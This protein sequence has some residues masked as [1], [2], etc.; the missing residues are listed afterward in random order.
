MKLQTITQVL[1]TLPRCAHLE[2]CMFRHLPALQFCCSHSSPVGLWGLLIRVCCL[3]LTKGIILK[4]LPLSLRLANFKILTLDLNG[5]CVLVFYFKQKVLL[6][7]IVTHQKSLY[8]SWISNN[9]V[10]SL[11]IWYQEIVDQW[12]SV[13]T[14]PVCVH[15]VNKTAPHA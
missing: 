13:I 1:V 10:K 9:R 5:A 14:S 11:S 4:T 7:L 3:F 2:L 8:A 12:N 6:T 15:G